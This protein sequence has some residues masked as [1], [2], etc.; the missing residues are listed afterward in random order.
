M[1]SAAPSAFTL[2]LPAE[3]SAVLYDSPHSGRYFPPEIATAATP[4]QLRWA[5]DAYLDELLSPSVE[6]GVPLLCA[7]WARAYLDLNRELTDIDTALLD[8]P[9]PGEVRP[10]D[11][12]RRGLELIRRFVVP[13]VA[14]YAAPL[15]VD[16]VTSR[17][18]RLHVPYHAQLDALIDETRRAHGGVWHVNWHSMKAVGNAMTPDGAGAARADFVVSDGDGTTAESRFTETVAEQL[19]AL[20]DLIA[21]GIQQFSN[22]TVRGRTDRMFHFH[23]FH[24]EQRHALLNHRTGI[25][26]QRNNLAGH[27]RSQPA[28]ICLMR[29]GMR[30][31]IVP[32]QLPVL[33]RVKDMKNIRFADHARSDGMT[34]KTNTDFTARARQCRQQHL[35]LLTAQP[36]TVMC[37]SQLQITRACG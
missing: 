22:L 8:A 37:I 21:D 15:R 6:L 12:T 30:N 1:S 27:R 25:H 34:V 4:L 3:R 35:A 26:Q 20:G 11:K 19:R 29:A 32:V 2:E 14:I 5:E 13:G 33:T 17:I 9:W 28:A 24:N 7:N 18:D 16:D 23:G 36:Q 31:R 10:T